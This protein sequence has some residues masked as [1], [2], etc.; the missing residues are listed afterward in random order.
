MYMGSTYTILLGTRVVTPLNDRVE[1][2]R[3]IGKCAVV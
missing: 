1:H 2:R 3:M